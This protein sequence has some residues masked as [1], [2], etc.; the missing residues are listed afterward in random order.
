VQEFHKIII[1]NLSP[2]TQNGREKFEQ[3]GQDLQDYENQT[4]PS[5]DLKILF[6]LTILFE[7]IFAY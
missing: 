5:P 7:I 1:T 2:R 4:Q 3:D 6:V